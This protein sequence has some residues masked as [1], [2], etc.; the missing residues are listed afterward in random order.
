MNRNTCL[1]LAGTVLVV[2]GAAGISTGKEDIGWMILFG[3]FAFMK[4]D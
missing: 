4:I 3:I 2:V 1:V